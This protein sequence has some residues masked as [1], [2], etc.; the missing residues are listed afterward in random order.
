MDREADLVAG[1][2]RKLKQTEVAG[3]ADKDFD[4]IS[5]APHGAS[6]KSR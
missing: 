2:L 1:G 5:E 4:V 6:H 3:I